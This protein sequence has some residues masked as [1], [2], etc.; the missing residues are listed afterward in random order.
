MGVRKVQVMLIMCL[1][2]KN[3]MK[4]TFIYVVFMNLWKEY[5]K[6]DR[7]YMWHLLQDYSTRGWLLRTTTSLYKASKVCLRGD[8]EKRGTF[9]CKSLEYEMD[10]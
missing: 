2:L 10:A 6:N 4:N 7:N 3:Y 1:S 5:D 9:S 8:R